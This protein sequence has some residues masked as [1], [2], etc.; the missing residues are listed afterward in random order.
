MGCRKGHVHRCEASGAGTDDVRDPLRHF[1]L[2][3]PL[4]HTSTVREI[5]RTV[6]PEQKP[7]MK[8]LRPIITFCII[9]CIF[10][11]C[12]RQ[13]APTTA[14][15]RATVLQ[16]EWFPFAGFAGEVSAS[17]RFAATNGICL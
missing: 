12:S 13:L 11:S 10:S 16:Q 14:N 6:V 4:Q 9:G 7:Q 15:G 3:T 5:P 1:A 8:S 17:R 2:S